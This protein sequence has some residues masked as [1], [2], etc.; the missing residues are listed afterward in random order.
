MVAFQV[1]ALHTQGQ[2][3]DVANARSLHF[4]Q[5]AV[6][7]GRRHRG[8]L[9]PA[10][11]GREAG[12]RQFQ[13]LVAQHVHA[14]PLAP[15]AQCLV[16]V[17][18]LLA[19]LHIEA[20]FQEVVAGNGHLAT[21]HEVAVALYQRVEHRHVGLPLLQGRGIGILRLL[22]QLERREHRRT[23]VASTIIV[24]VHRLEIARAEAQHVKQVVVEDAAV[25]ALL[26]HRGKLAGLVLCQQFG[27]LHRLAVI[28]LAVAKLRALLAILGSHELV[29]VRSHDLGQHTVVDRSQHG[30]RLLGS[31]RLHPEHPHGGH[32]RVGSHLHHQRRVHELRFQQMAVALLLLS[33][34]D[35]LLEHCYT[36]LG[37]VALPIFLHLPP[38]PVVAVGKQLHWVHT[39]QNHYYE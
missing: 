24:V 39:H 30:M 6:F 22:C 11:I 23:P 26:N 36:R 8:Y 4:Q 12:F 18:N 38:E 35:N 14:F 19:G 13:A 17:G 7:R 15:A 10:A 9:R 20:V 28:V 31:Q 37:Q 27:I 5:S 2:A 21:L 25:G 29:V 3:L 34:R 32:Q 16:D 1:D 33:L